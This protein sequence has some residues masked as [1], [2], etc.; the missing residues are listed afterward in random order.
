MATLSASNGR[1]DTSRTREHEC[2]PAPR[3]IEHRWHSGCTRP[4]IG[5]PTR[6]LQEISISP[7]RRVP[8]TAHLPDLP[9]TA[10]TTDTRP[11]GGS[12]TSIMNHRSLHAHTPSRPAPA[13]EATLR[14]EI[15]LTHVSIA[16]TLLAALVSLGT[17]T[18]PLLE[19]LTA[20]RWGSGLRQTLFVVIVSVLIYGGI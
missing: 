7:D 11:S 6:V 15:V 14:R 17:L 8:L 3:A 9:H 1:R 2:F 16:I 13:Y 20:H 10:R 18:G 4:A 12:L 19:H 5:A